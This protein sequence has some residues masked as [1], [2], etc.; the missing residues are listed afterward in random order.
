[1]FKI[2]N[3]SAY[4][5]NINIS[6]P[7]ELKT[8]NSLSCFNKP[9]P[10]DPSFQIYIIYLDGRN[11]SHYVTQNTL[12][13]DLKYT[14]ISQIGLTKDDIRL[15]YQN[16]ELQ[17]NLTLKQLDINSGST[18]Y[19]KLILKGG[20]YRQNY[21]DTFPNAN[22]QN[23]DIKGN[24]LN[25]SNIFDSFLNDDNETSVENSGRK[26]KIPIKNPRKMHIEV[27]HKVGDDSREIDDEYT[28]D[29]QN[30]DDS[31][32]THLKPSLKFLADNDTTIIN[33]LP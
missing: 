27:N 23:F 15:T 5:Q 28:L 4:P 12:I 26:I 13:Q 2:I 20:M 21:Q 24:L 6:I 18:L 9:K 11:V 17:Q 7:L 19:L 31:I 1:M 14:I 32:Q 8:S 16:K 29:L 33:K 22:G 10:I 30:F 3:T 25:E